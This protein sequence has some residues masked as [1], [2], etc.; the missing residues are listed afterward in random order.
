M[1]W[2][3]ATLCLLCAWAADHQSE[4]ATLSLSYH[5]P[6]ACTGI[7]CNRYHSVALLAAALGIH[8]IQV[9]KEA[10]KQLP[11][12]ML[13]A[14]ESRTSRVSSALP[15]VVQGP[16]E[17]LI[18][19]RGFG[20]MFAQPAIQPLRRPIERRIEDAAA[21]FSARA[22]CSA[23][24]MFGCDAAWLWRPLQKSHSR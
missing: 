21:P 9:Q 20:L 24:P 16:P 19:E 18:W 10:C 14:H 13:L 15:D 1:P 23:H 17:S 8:V 6:P 5:R 4:Q 12:P 2:P 22:T 7:W 11:G 3:E